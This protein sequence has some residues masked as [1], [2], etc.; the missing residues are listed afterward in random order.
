MADAYSLRR[1]ALDKVLVDAAVAAGVEVRERYPVAEILFGDRVIG[2]RSRGRT[3][4]ARIVIG[5]DGLGSLV[6]R[7]VDARVY[8]DHGTLTCA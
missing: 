2:I 8:N 6:A 5:A 1:T 3:D 4:R 7:S